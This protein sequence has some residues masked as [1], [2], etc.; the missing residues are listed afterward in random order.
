VPR[1]GERYRQKKPDSKKERWTNAKAISP[2]QELRKH[3][4]KQCRIKILRPIFLWSTQKGRQGGRRRD[5]LSGWGRKGP[6]KL[7]RKKAIVRAYSDLVSSK[8]PKS[9]PATS[10]RE[11]GKGKHQG[12][13]AQ[14][15]SR[16]SGQK[17]IFKKTDH[18]DTERKSLMLSERKKPTKNS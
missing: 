4:G 17:K 11:R 2:L 6:L 9:I 14:F 12:G 7:R 15:P 16:S 3:H 5:S 10:K 18:H 13:G 1:E 8:N